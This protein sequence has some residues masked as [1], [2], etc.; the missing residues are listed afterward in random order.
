MTI[1]IPHR[2]S[3]FLLGD[4]AVQI[5]ID[6]FIDIQCPHSRK[7]WP[8]LLEVANYYKNKSVSLRGT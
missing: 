6:A 4:A 8:T 2:P 5:T 3:G 1:P 7:I